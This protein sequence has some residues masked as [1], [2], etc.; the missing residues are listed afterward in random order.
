MTVFAYRAADRRGQTVAGVMEAPDA[1]AVVER[2]QR[3]AYTDDVRAAMAAAKPNA[4]E[5]LAI[6]AAYRRTMRAD[7]QRQIV[8][9]GRRLAALLENLHAADQHSDCRR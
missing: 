5:P 7:A 2:L 4:M 6:G 1:R 8:L 3:D 9:A